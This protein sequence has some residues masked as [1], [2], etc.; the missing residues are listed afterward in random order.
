M[1]SN[2]LTLGVVFLLAAGLCL[3]TASVLPK[4]PSSSQDCEQA[5]L[6]YGHFA[7]EPVREEGTAPAGLRAAIVGTARLARE[8]L[9][10]NLVGR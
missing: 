7:E 5:G 9:K 6:T 10:L 3:A 1:A 4:R 8:A 2:K